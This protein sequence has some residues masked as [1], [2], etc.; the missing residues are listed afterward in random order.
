MHLVLDQLL[1][2]TWR[3]THVIANRG[4]VLVALILVALPPS[5]LRYVRNIA[6][7]LHLLQGS[8]CMVY[9]TMSRDHI[10]EQCVVVE[11]VLLAIVVLDGGK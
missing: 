6:L 11:G 7:F 8:W 3:W 4:S 5:L 10:R 9:V 2:Y 1:E